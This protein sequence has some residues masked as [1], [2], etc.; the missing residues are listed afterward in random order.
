MKAPLH[1]VNYLLEYSKV[2]DEKPP[3]LS[4]LLD[5][6]SRSRLLQ[7]ASFFLGL[8]NRDSEF[9]H[10][11]D[12]IEMFF[13]EENNDFAQGVYDKVYAIDQNQEEGIAIVSQQSM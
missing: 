13:R 9:Q 10:Y 8:A 2:F 6:I 5:G 7:V 12:L 4:A 11:K 1:T 3:E